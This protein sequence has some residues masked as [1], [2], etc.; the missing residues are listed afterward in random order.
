MPNAR[1]Q[2]WTP[3]SYGIKLDST[4]T[5]EG[6]EAY[7]VRGIGGYL[8][9]AVYKTSWGVWCAESC[10]DEKWYY[11]TKDEAVHRLTELCDL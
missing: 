6:Y 9:G 8:N 2:F 11:V 1:K 4:K 10:G 7:L 5:H 3:D